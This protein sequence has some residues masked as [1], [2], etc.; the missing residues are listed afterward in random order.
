MVRTG[1][2]VRSC[3]LAQCANELRE[4]DSPPSRLSAHTLFATLPTLAVATSRVHVRVPAI[5]G[6]HGHGHVVYG[7]V[8]QSGLM[9]W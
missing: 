8:C 1:S 4:G 7:V 3:Q 9:E 5:W 6:W 2:A